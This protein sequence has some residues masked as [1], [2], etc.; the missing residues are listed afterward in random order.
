M[1]V[2]IYVYFVFINFTNL[3]LGGVIFRLLIE[4]IM[5]LFTTHTPHK[6]K[7]IILTS[8]LICYSYM[9]I[10][11]PCNVYLFFFSSIVLSLINLYLFHV[12]RYP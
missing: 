1:C 12:Y 6:K 10:I 9:I 5:L 4:I 2:C 3:K 7:C 11:I 8:Y